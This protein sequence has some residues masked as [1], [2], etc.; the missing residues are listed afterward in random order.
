MPFPRSLKACLTT[1]V[2]AGALLTGV[3]GPAQA[4]NQGTV[5][6]DPAAPPGAPLT[7]TPAT[8]PGVATP[9]AY[10]YG[11]CDGA[12]FNVHKSKGFASVHAR[13]TC[14]TSGLDNNVATNIGYVG[15]FGERYAMGRGKQTEASAKSYCVGKGKQTW[16]AS[17]THRTIIG[18]TVFLARTGNSASF[19][20]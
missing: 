8:L 17:S 7:A 13:T 18:N 3:A 9:L 5:A 20:C 14:K 4:V 12:T 1:A 16:S 2:L 10:V 19:T 15:W 6:V 11:G